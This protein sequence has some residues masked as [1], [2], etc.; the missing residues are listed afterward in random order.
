MATVP[1][2]KQQGAQAA[3]GRRAA[4]RHALLRPDGGL[5]S[6]GGQTQSARAKPMVASMIFSSR[7]MAPICSSFSK[8]CLGA[9][10]VSFISGG[11]SCG[12]ESTAPFQ[13]APQAAHQAA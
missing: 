1:G 8:A 3:G 6:G 9:S 13:S 7:L 10:G 11:A 4:L 5:Q 12:P 2:E